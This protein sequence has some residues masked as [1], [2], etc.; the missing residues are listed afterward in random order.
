MKLKQL[1]TLMLRLMGVYCFILSIP[2]LGVFATVIVY[3]QQV[4]GGAKTSA[5]I[6]S[7]LPAAGLLAMGTLLISFAVAWGEKLCLPAAN[8]A[9]VSVASFEQV[10]VL[11]FAMAGVLIFADALPQLINCVSYLIGWVAA[12][13]EDWQKEGPYRDYRFREGAVAAGTVLKAIL[14]LVLFFRARGVANFWRSLRTFA[15]PKPPTN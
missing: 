14:G 3:S 4:A 8:D 7:L 1:A 11:A 12:G 5:L 13:R 9:D 2:M 15:T 6:A 10:Q